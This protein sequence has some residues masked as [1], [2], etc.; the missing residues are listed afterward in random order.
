M[1]EATQAPRAGTGHLAGA[2]ALGAWVEEVASLDAFPEALARAGC[3]PNR[4][5]ALAA[6][7][8]LTV[9]RGS[10]PVGCGCPR[11]KRSRG[12]ARC[13]GRAQGRAQAP[14]HRSLIRPAGLERSR[15]SGTDR[16]VAS[17]HPTIID[18]ARRAACR[19]PLSR[20]S[21]GAPNVGVERRARGLAAAEELAIAPTQWLGAWSGSE[22]ICSASCSPTSTTR[23]SPRWSTG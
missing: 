5:V 12:G 16:V 6:A 11:S 20:W 19:S 22:P 14:A 2:A 21:C 18:A 1:L 8:T 17:S 15:S 23:T 4:C 10:T 7:W 13:Q 9:D 3:L